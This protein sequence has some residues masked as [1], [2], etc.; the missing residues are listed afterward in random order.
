MVNRSSCCSLV[1][2]HSIIQQRDT[3]HPATLVLLVSMKNF[4]G[5]FRVTCFGFSC[6]FSLCLI[7]HTAGEE[8]MCSRIKWILL[9][10]LQ[11]RLIKTQLI[12]EHLPWRSLGFCRSCGTGPS[13]KMLRSSN[14]LQKQSSVTE[15]NSDM[16]PD[17]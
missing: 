15:S 14:K 1:W 12:T 3:Q 13:R 17:V 5:L 4:W 8:E 10:S 2:K 9:E 7:Y 11:L 16:C 6:I